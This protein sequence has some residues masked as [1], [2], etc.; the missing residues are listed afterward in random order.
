MNDSKTFEFQPPE[1]NGII[2]NDVSLYYFQSKT[3]ANFCMR[4]IQDEEQKVFHDEYIVKGSP[5]HFHLKILAILYA[6]ERLFC[7]FFNF[8][9][10][11][12]WEYFK[13]LERKIFTFFFFSLPLFLFF[14]V[15]IQIHGSI[16]KQNLFLLTNSHMW[17]LCVV[18]W[19]GDCY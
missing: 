18:F 1:N 16:S 17:R 9:D 8:I 4:K 6:A 5:R 14:P 2:S 7:N 15:S 11:V 12:I 19:T 10:W 13:C 3:K